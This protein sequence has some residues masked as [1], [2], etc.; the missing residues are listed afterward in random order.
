MR[1]KLLVIGAGPVGLGMANALKNHGIP[2][3]QVDANADLGGNWQ[4][5]VYDTVHIVSSKRTTAYRDYPMPADYPDFPSA[6][7]MLDYLKAFARD[8]GLAAHIEYNKKVVMAEPLA[9]DSWKVRFEDGDERHYKGVIVCNGHHWDRK[10]PKFDGTFMG[11]L[12]HSKDYKTPDQLRGKRVLVLGAGNSGCDLACEAARV[13]KS[14]DLSLRGGYWFFPKT[15]FGKPLTDLPIW[16]LPLFLQRLILKGIIKV[17]IGDYRKY[18]LER[19]NHKI[20]DRHPTFGTDLLNYLAQ[21]RIKPRKE[22]AQVDGTTVTFKD[23]TQGEY[24]MIAAATGFRYS[25]PFLPEGMVEVENDVVQVYGGAFPDS[26]KNLYIVGASQPR[27]GF[28]H[29]L[30]PAADVYAQLIKLQDELEHPIGAIL[31][32]LDEKIPDSQFLDPGQT[33]RQLYV[34]RRAMWYVKWQGGRMAKK[35]PYRSL[36]AAYQAE[37]ARGADAG[38]ASSAKGSQIAA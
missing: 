7:L 19:P 6:A 31:A 24:D 26:A 29:V 10:M 16:T 11:E 21:G 4:S 23:G 18:G 36:G 17:F 13:G 28:G 27:G 30:S 14:C 34:A 5:G 38:R 25:F 32:W 22:I 35:E 3:E 2:Y 20:F 12:I 1:D 8:K 15:A 33:F 37:K 9:D